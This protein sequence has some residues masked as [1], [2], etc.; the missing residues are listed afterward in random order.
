MLRTS[1]D[2]RDAA[3]A[4]ARRAPVAALICLTIL[5]V[6]CYGGTLF[7]GRQ[8]A[9]RD[10]AHFYYP[11]EW[12]VQREWSAGR[13]P[14]WNP[15]ANGGM[16][17]LGSPMAA[18]LYPGKLVFALVPYAWG[19]RL[20]TVG[21]EVLAFGAMLALMRCWGVSRPGATL[22]GLSYAFGGPVL[23]D[24]FNII[25]LVGAAWLPLGF[26]A[27]DRWLR[28][29]RRVGL[30]ELAVVLAMQVLGGDPEAAYLTLVCAFGYAA[31]LARSESGMPARPALWGLGLAAVAGA[32][33]WAGPV[34]SRLIHGGG[35]G[36]GQAVLAATWAVGV[37][38]YAAT[39]RPGHRGRLAA[40][41]LGLA[42]A[43]TLALL[44]AAAQ[45]LPVAHHLA[46]SGRWAGSGPEL[47][48]D[49]SL[50][51]Y[52]AFEWIWP[53]V[54]GTF[55]AGNRY[56]IPILPP[57]GA[58]HPAPLTL[59]TGALPWVLALAAAGS[60][61]GPPWR[62]WMTAV[63]LLSFW[64][65][66]GQFAGPSGWLTSDP[67]SAAGD[68]SFYGLLVAALPGL[69]LFRFPFKLLALTCLGLSALAGLGWDR[70]AAGAGRRRTIALLAGLLVP[71]ILCLSA[72]LALRDQVAAAIAARG[73]DHAVFG[74]LDAQR[75]AA[76]IVRA[77]AHGAIAL[78]AG[79]AIALAS[80]GRWRSV[81]AGMS[82][83]VV[84]ADLAIANAPWIITIPQADFELEPAVLRAIR[85]VER[86]DPSPGPF[87]IQRLPSWAPTGWSTSS[88]PRRLRELVDWEI[89]TLQPS[90]GWLHGID[91]VFVDESETARAD[92]RRLF[93]PSSRVLDPNLSAALGIEPGRPILYHPRG[94]FDLFGAVYFIVPSSPDAWTAVNRS[95]AAFVDQTELIYPDP[96]S[97]EGPEHLKDRERWMLTR[98]VQV[99]RNR[100]AFPR[101]WVVHGARLIR[102]IDESHPAERDALIA[103]LRSA[104]AG[105][106][107]PAS[108]QRPEL[109]RIAH[110]E[111]DDPAAVAAY[112]PGD[113]RNRRDDDIVAVRQDGPTRV[114]IEAT[115]RR[116]GIVVLSDTFD[117]GWRLTID[118]RPEPIL[119]ANLVMRAAAV[120][121]GTHTIVYTYEPPSVR[122]GARISLA[123]LA[124]LV[125]F[126][127]WRG[128]GQRGRTAPIPRRPDNRLSSGRAAP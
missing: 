108:S 72:V 92:Q 32:W 120:P 65:S 126:I 117:D 27:A 96:A 83:A 112:L 6:A 33:L 44:L 76:A 67:T 79:L 106:P 105:D 15:G 57:A 48:Y 90:F 102:P 28:L 77:L 13:L 118:G 85:E 17:L 51:P 62:A 42:A 121:A 20:Y 4:A 89:D 116:P 31:G 22:A 109:L 60:K 23:S 115:L 21:H 34:V 2:L 49:S 11:L 95:Y 69:R 73:F 114:T 37:A 110:I 29:G 70:L 9:F 98:D 10:S 7:G 50:V 52:R 82:L 104:D 88:S 80:A 54:F 107:A 45:V 91:Y 64:A 61:G 68:E 53:N 39:R 35:G 55:T 19:I 123:G 93:Q 125:G 14:L 100:R 40:G 75:S 43:G 26:R 18:V 5:I 3:A 124:A 113:D 127:V 59:Y 101:A 78:A 128:P 87:R 30:A 24:Y 119:R 1:A 25:Y 46:A 63:A 74:P 8:F 56:W 41:W 16:P 36:R 97:L 99:R 71:T 103:R 12:R 84:T 86:R 122:A 47:L 94:V 58:Q 66:L 111:T 81:A 38:W